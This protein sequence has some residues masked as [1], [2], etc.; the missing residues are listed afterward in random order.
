[1][2]PEKFKEIK[3]SV[4]NEVLE[5]MRS[6]KPKKE[7]IQKVKIGMDYVKAVTSGELQKLSVVVQI[8]GLYKPE[9]RAEIAKKIVPPI[10]HLIDSDVQIV[11]GNELKKLIEAKEKAFKEASEKREEAE[12]TR[13][14]KEVV[15]QQAAKDVQNLQNKIED[16]KDEKK[17]KEAPKL[18]EII[19]EEYRQKRDILK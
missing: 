4:E 1:M 2:N 5:V 19:E 8:A 18:Q 6:P 13:S 14:E 12:R 11:P 15:Q 9:D 3:D 17:T 7:S 16:M 10:Y